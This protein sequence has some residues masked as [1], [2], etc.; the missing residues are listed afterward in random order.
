MIFTV[1]I[2]KAIVFSVKTHEMYQKQKRKG[3][4]IPYITHPLTVGLILSRANASEDVVIA[5]LL[6]DTIEDSKSD[7]KVT[8]EML[9]ERFGKNVADLVMSVTE[10][11]KDLPWEERKNEA[12]EHIKTFSHDSLLVKSADLISNGSEI[13]DDYEK[14]GVA[15]FDR[16]SAPKHRVIWHYTEAMKAILGRWSENPFTEDL[17]GLIARFNEIELEPS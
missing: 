16:F 10:Q 7:K 5:G 6:H 9:V 8:H 4:D 12:I 13:L 3:K 1:K 2:E 11:R 17:R 14:E 15:I